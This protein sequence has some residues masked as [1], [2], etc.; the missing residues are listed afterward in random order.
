MNMPNY[1]VTPERMRELAKEI[2]GNGLGLMASG[3][4][5]TED[6]TLVTAGSLDA[7]AAILTQRREDLSL[8]E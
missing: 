8:K 2:R 5:L 7:M 1:R 3:R 6:E 4:Q